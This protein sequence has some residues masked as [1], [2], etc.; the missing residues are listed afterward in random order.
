MTPLRR[1]IRDPSAPRRPARAFTLLELLLA[2]GV[3]L[4][5]SGVVYGAM[6]VSFRAARSVEGAIQAGAVAERG[7]GVAAG[8]IAGAARPTGIL[9]GGFAGQDVADDLGRPVDVLSFHTSHPKFLAAEPTIGWYR[10]DLRVVPESAVGSAAQA[11]AGAFDAART[12]GVIDFD[13]AALLPDTVEVAALDADLAGETMTAAD[14]AGVLVRDITVDLLASDEPAIVRQVLARRV[15]GFDVRYH[16]GEEWQDEWFSAGEDNH[17]PVAVEL[18]LT[19]NDADATASADGAALTNVSTTT[20]RRI[21]PMLLG[22]S[23]A[24]RIL[25]ARGG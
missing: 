17:L 16:N 1:D 19:L 22:T 9:S 6:R 10:V 23:E 15:V 3:G 13:A 20:V 8:D 11:A 14:P 7:L 18:A 21:V 24:A 12:R 4:L 2:L 25:E 5:V